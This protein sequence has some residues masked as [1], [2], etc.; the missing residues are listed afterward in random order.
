MRNRISTIAVALLAAAGTAGLAAL[1]LFTDSG[2][3]FP[4]TLTT[5]A[6]TTT[7][8]TT[9]RPPATTT[10]Q[11][12]PSSTTSS[13]TTTESPAPIALSV[14]NRRDGHLARDLTAFYTWMADPSAPEP[15]MADGLA[16]HL[17]PARTPGPLE[18][19][20]AVHRDTLADGSKVAVVEVG[21][22]LILAVADGGT[23][24]IVGADLPRFGADPWFGDPVRHILVLGTDARPHQ[25][26]PEFRADSIHLLGASLA[27]QGGA[28]VGFPRDTWV[29][30]SYGSDKL[31]NVNVRGGTA[32]LV[33]I[34]GDL[35]GI[36]V[37]GYLLTGFAGF[38][39]LVNAFGGV[40]V[41]IPFRMADGDSNA[42]LAA[43]LQI[44]R[45]GDALAFSR[46]R[47]IAGGDF[48]RSRHQGIVI[49]AGLRGAQAMGIEHLPR[50][51]RIL[52][53]DTWTDLSATELL[54]LGAI[55]FALDPD[56]VGNVV[57][58]G[59]VGTVGNSS[60]VWLTSGAGDVFADLADGVVNPG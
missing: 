35:S 12:P 22:D 6:S 13:T 8:S 34:A 7:T 18:L 11:P 52:T 42:F 30:T 36:E 56:R 40:E 28:I 45:G 32:E 20:A 4:T 19:A 41:D 48:T 5:S 33:S 1:V 9:T 15:L 38:K 44:L 31:T 24:R 17:A 2:I 37:D 50:L 23:W 46:N 55:A 29:A 27:E 39:H 59:E 57:L 49:S 21:D 58:P 10:T 43:G 54:Q 47:H 3:E 26:Q 53:E 16:D 60:V 14:I 25:S 51:L